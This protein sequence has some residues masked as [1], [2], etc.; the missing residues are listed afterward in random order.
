MTK[1]KLRNGEKID[2]ILKV[3]L[4]SDGLVCIATSCVRRVVIIVQMILLKFEPPVIMFH[5]KF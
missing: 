2:L 5:A 4:V 1:K 3:E